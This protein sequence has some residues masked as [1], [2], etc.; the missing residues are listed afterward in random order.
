MFLLMLKK[1]QYNMGGEAKMFRT[2]IVLHCCRI[3]VIRGMMAC[4]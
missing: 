2:S 3:P 4:S 1:P